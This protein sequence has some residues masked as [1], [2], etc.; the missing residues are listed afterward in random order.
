LAAE[1]GYVTNGSFFLAGD[2]VLARSPTVLVRRV[3]FLVMVGRIC[4]AHISVL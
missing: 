2:L 3:F 4:F 1:R